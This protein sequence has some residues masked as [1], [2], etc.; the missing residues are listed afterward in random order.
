MKARPRLRGS[1][2]PPGRSSPRSR[3]SLALWQLVVW[4][5]WKP[6]YVLP[7]P[8]AVRPK[9]WRDMV[10]DEH[11]LERHRHHRPARA[12][13]G[14]A[15]PWCSACCSASRSPASAVLR[16]A[17]G[18]MI[19]GA[20]DDAVDRLVPAGDPALP[21]QRAGD[22]LRGGAGRGTVDRQRSHRRRRLRAAAAAAGRAQPRRARARRSTGTSSC[23]ASLPSHRRRAQAGLGVRLAQPDGRRAARGHRRAAVARGRLQI[24]RRGVRRGP[25]H[26]H[27]DRHPVIGIVVDSSSMSRTTRSA[28]GG[29]SRTPAPEPEG[30][31]T[32]VP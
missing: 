11:V 3:W 22:L 27:D 1:G 28:G 18:S 24:A 15:S 13:S 26:R 4:S 17:I 29:V 32:G 5:G 21:A 12:S 30:R 16:A 19:T 20:A 8:A 31:R 6:E 9:L 2:R 10:S 14:S 7:A 25:A 23:P